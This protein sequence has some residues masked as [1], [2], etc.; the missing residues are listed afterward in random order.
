MFTQP[1]YFILFILIPLFLLFFIWRG[2]VR[3]IALRRIGDE[4]LV[5]TLLSQISHG[6]RRFKLFLWLVT[7][8]LLIFA[9]ARPTWGVETE[10]VRSEGVQIIFTLDI[11]RSMNA[12][13]MSPSRL[14]RAQLDI[15]NLL[16][17]LADN[18]VGMVLFA[19]S[20]FQYMPLT[21]DMNVAEIFL[22]AVTTDA[23]TAQGTNI[24]AAIE[25]ALNSFEARSTAQP[26]MVLISDGESHEGDTIIAAQQAA[27]ANVTIHTLGYGTEAGANVPIFNEDGELINYRTFAD[28]TLVTTRLNPQSLQQIASI[29][30]GT[31]QQ[32]ARGGSITPVIE[33][34]HQAQATSARDEWS[35]RPIERFGIFVAVAIL[36]LSLEML[37]PE[38]R[39]G[40]I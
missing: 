32:M 11:S 9:L 17:S 5:S 10:R 23:A 29:T 20:A 6:R 27:A 3:S 26:I 1:L 19:R 37:L 7:L 22:N 28:G 12:D 35:T 33:A 34:L 30:G 14:K 40:R 4:A 25:I 21:S 39:K 36:L 16:N 15:H 31:Y 13:D 38:G 24:P 8:S 2:L 18:D